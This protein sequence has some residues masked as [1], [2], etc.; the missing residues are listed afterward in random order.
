MKGDVNQKQ[1]LNT[2]KNTIEE[3]TIFSKILWIIVFI[4]FILLLVQIFIKCNL[5]Q[6]TPSN[7]AKQKKYEKYLN[8]LDQFYA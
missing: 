2:D 8:E 6:Y 1:E 5:S 7:R 4:S 3:N